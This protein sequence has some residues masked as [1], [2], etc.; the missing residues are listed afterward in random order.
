MAYQSDAVTKAASAFEARWTMLSLKRVDEELHDALAEQ[1]ELYYQAMINGA[2]DDQDI[3]GKALVRGYAEAVHAME[4]ANMPDD[5]YLTGEY[6][7]LMVVVSGQKVVFDRWEER[8]HIGRI[9]IISPDE[10]AYLFSTIKGL[11]QIED[12]KR[13][14]PGAEIIERIKEE[15]S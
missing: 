8:N 6:E 4:S 13:M 5:S 15:T 9:I 11:E 10:I 2:S 12:I 14:F 1:R 3:Q 7:G